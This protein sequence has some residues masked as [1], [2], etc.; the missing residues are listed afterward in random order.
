MWTTLRPNSPK[1]E[2]DPSTR[3][4][5][6]PSFG[7]CSVS[8]HASVWHIR[9]PLHYTVQ[10]LRYFQKFHQACD[11]NILACSMP[12]SHRASKRVFKVSLRHWSPLHWVAEPCTESLH[13]PNK[14]S[15]SLLYE[16][17]AVL[18]WESDTR[19]NAATLNQDYQNANINS[20]GS[21]LLGEIDFLYMNKA[22]NYS[23]SLKKN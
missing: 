7:V 15:L 8:P 5:V 20:R 6:H 13:W 4:S 22:F 2:G 16:L 17:T 11:L 14:N 1:R 12:L 23:R 19:V 3:G 21:C 10:I 18:Q 9:S